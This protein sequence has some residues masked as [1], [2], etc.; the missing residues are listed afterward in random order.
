MTYPPT[1][2]P[3]PHQPKR[4]IPTIGIIGI[5]I[6]ALLLMCCA[7]GTALSL[8]SGDK[9]E[10]S[11]PPPTSAPQGAP[12]TTPA[13]VPANMSRDDFVTLVTRVWPTFN[14]DSALRW[15]E[16]AC[17]Q[18]DHHGSPQAALDSYLAAP[19]DPSDPTDTADNLKLV[20]AASLHTFCAQ[21]ATGHPP[22]IPPSK[23]A[24]PKTVFDT[25]T[26]EV[27]VEVKAGTYTCKAG[28]SDGYWERAKDA[29]GTIDAIIANG[30]V[31]AGSQT[32]VT[33]K[34]KEFFKAQQLSCTIR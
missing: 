10:P 29:S 3:Q 28:A 21:H 24:G 19:R 22:A 23:P 32:I 8:L 30:I 26:Y 9:P 5:I 12:A 7:G 33:V 13:A 34:A 2:T 11:T 25:G 16:T 4:R 18:V 6:G 31:S 17:G 27:G 14:R 20:W 1:P 15:G